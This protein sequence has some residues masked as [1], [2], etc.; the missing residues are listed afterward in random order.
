MRFPTAPAKMSAAQIIKPLWY[1]F[2]IKPLIKNAPQITATN[3]NR[4]K[5]I[6]PKSPPNFKPHA[7][8]SFSTK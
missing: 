7:I 5:I 6:F 3:L 8:P 1:F 2:A 4:V